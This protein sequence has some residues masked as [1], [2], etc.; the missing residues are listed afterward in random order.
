MPNAQ[1]MRETMIQKGIPE[2]I[3]AQFVFPEPNCP[4]EDT[5]GLIGQ[6]D[7]LLTKEQ[8][9]SIMEEEG[10]TKTGEPDRKHRAFGRR[11][12]RK[13]VEERIA[14]MKR[15]LRTDHKAPCHINP[16]GT[17]SVYWGFGRE[18]GRYDCVCGQIMELPEHIEVSR[19]YCGCCAGHIRHHYQNSL[20][21]TLRLK[22]I[23]SSPLDSDG[24]NRCE[25][26]F[27]I[28]G[29]KEAFHE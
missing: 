10:C 9:M 20:G 4:V 16:D 29:E 13:T 5:I 19:T 11:Y 28:L 21:V 23:V 8:C 26:L 3:M 27:E 14:L 17:L 2:E 7:R 22:D 25:I 1:Q 6:M 18:E 12:K 15:K 24:K